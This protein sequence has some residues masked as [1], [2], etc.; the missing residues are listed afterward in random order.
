MAV[1][2]AVGSLAPWRESTWAK[3]IS[4]LLGKSVSMSDSTA[5]K[6]EYCPQLWETLG[7]H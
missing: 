5:K 4:Q 3:V 1:F 2:D 7:S 6:G